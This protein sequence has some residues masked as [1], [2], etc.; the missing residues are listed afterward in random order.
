LADAVKEEKME[1]LLDELEMKAKETL[2]TL[3]NQVPMIYLDVN[4]RLKPCFLVFSDRYSK[5]RALQT[6]RERI[7]KENIQRYWTVMETWVSQ[8]KGIS[9]HEDINRKEMIMISEYNGETMENKKVLLPFERQFDDEELLKVS[10][11]IR[12]MSRNEGYELPLV[13]KEDLKDPM[14]MKILR[15]LNEDGDW[16]GKIVWGCKEAFAVG[17]IDGVWVDRWNFYM[18]DVSKEMDEKMEKQ[19]IEALVKE[20]QELDLTDFYRFAERMRNGLMEKQNNW[21][22]NI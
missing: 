4:G 7:A 13:T 18:E 11:R 9:P 5:E 2:E 19:R 15:Q 10:E 16:A 8:T 6:F 20:M 17:G 12:E 21:F 1:T 3:G 14:M 22:Q